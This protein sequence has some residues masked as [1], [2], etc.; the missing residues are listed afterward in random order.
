MRL[1]EST[2]LAL[3]LFSVA[4]ADPRTV[5]G[6]YRNPALGY[7]VKV[8]QGLIGEAGD[9]SGPERGLE[10]SLPS[11]GTI[12]VYG[13]PNSLEWKRPVEGV[14]RVLAGEKCDGERRREIGKAQVGKLIGAMGR[15][16]CDNKVLQVLLAFR[17]AGGPIYW[18]TLRTNPTHQHEDELIFKQFATTFKLIHWQ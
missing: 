7:S 1:I 11:G 16:A 5:K 18:L 4:G 15:L 17:S 3:L 2:I 9:Q 14:E 8:P 6:L 10:F 12:S 13:E